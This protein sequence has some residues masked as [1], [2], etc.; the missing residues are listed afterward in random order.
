M[1]LSLNTP[2]SHTTAP[3]ATLTIPDGPRLP[4]LGQS[5][6]LPCHLQCRGRTC[7]SNRFH[8]DRAWVT[9]V[10]SSAP[11]GQSG[12]REVRSVSQREDPQRWLS[13]TRSS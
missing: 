10:R 9:T 5:P 1:Q 6:A 8:P 7:F 11:G 12:S 4:T 2:L 13:R 3:N